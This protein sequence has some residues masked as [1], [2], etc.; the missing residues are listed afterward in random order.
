[1]N[2][3]PERPAVHRTLVTLVTGFLG[4]G[5]TTL[6]NAAMHDPAMT[7]TLIVINEF[8]EIGLDHALVTNSSDTILVLENGCL[9]CTVFGDLIG[10]LNTA[11]HRREA[12]EV[13]P[14][15]RVIIETSGL[16]DPTTIVQAFLSDPTLEGL[17]RLGSVIAV[18]DAVNLAQTLYDHDEATRQIALADRI[19]ITKL[20]LVEPDERIAAEARSR[21]TIR[22]INPM[23]PILINGSDDW[24]VVRLL[25]WEQSD[26]AGGG[27]AAERWLG[28][29]ADQHAHAHDSAGSHQHAPVE[30]FTFVRADPLPRLAL[31]LLLEGIE[32]NL[33]PNLLRLKAIVAVEGEDGAAVIHGVQHLLHNITWLETWP[34]PDRNSRFVLIAAGIGRAQLS[35]MVELLDRIATRSAAARPVAEL[36]AV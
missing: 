27:A 22:R 9:C 29:A 7:N 23:A 12:G 31:Q 4:S 18:A 10:T 28:A 25:C 34:F 8:G 1:M 17:Y 20:D 19:V 26:P 36:N 13:P 5:K 11:Y 21:E 16:A 14:F 24:D 32:R 33:G 30:S 35:E 6:V 2:G 3:S 15:D